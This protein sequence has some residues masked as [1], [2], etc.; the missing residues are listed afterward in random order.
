M[1]C[2]DW[3]SL[4]ASR[5]ADP[6]ADSAAW[7]SARRHLSGC[8]RCRPAALAAEPLLLFDRL[9]ARLVDAGEIADMQAGV[10]A[11]LRAAR[12][13][14]R[15]LAGSAPATAGA[16]LWRSASRVAALLGG[17]ALLLLSGSRS[18]SSPS[19]P[20]SPSSPS[21]LASSNP[22]QIAPQFAD[23]AHAAHA[24]DAAADFAASRTGGFLLARD[25]GALT[26]A[27]A[28]SAVEELDRP[29]ARIYELPQRDMAVVMIVDASLDV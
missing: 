15:S 12:V 21:S 13:E 24:A 5:E 9:P 7:E 19:S 10:G 22:T 8:D 3:S 16:E 18:P 20:W 11:L 14:Q 23:A 27:P 25:P 1:T 26:A 28:Q 4:A 2:P 29:G 6:G 17:C